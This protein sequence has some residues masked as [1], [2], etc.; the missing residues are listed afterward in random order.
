MKKL[1]L[2][3]FPFCLFAQE[4]VLSKVNIIESQIKYIDSIANL[5]EEEMS[6]GL[7]KI[8]HSKCLENPTYT[9]TSL[10]KDSNNILRICYRERHNRNF[11]DFHIYFSNSKIIYIELIKWKGKRKIFSKKLYYE[12][13]LLIYPNYSSKFDI[14]DEMDIF[15]KAKRIK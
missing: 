2:I 4:N 15:E 10:L 13:E 5:R 3:L 12:N 8:S 1:L 6:I 9:N 7:I 14:K 11:E